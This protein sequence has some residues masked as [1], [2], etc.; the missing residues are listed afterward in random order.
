MQVYL[1]DIRMKQH[2]LD[3]KLTEAAPV[4]AAPKQKPSVPLAP[5][6]DKVLKKQ[7]EQAIRAENDRSREPP[8][9]KPVAK[10]PS[11]T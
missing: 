3:K 1:Q 11:K 6:R 5:G 7:K 9:K 2:E 8:A 4:Q 10:K